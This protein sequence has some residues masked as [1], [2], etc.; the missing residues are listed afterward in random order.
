M[1]LN[2]ERFGSRINNRVTASEF[3]WT[4]GRTGWTGRR[5]GSPWQSGH[6]SSQK[7]QSGSWGVRSAS[8]HH[9]ILVALA[10]LVR[11]HRYDMALKILS[12]ELGD[13]P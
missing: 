3:A 5:E 12:L 1:N 4:L 8:E 2:L 7:S 9:K 13:R 10:S 11:A 6:V